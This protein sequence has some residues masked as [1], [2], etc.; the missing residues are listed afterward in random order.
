MLKKAFKLT[1][2]IVLTILVILFSLSGLQWAI[3]ILSSPVHYLVFS[4]AA[5]LAIVIII[6]VLMYFNHLINII[7]K[8]T[9]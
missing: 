3:G 5:V 2:Y 8:E 6:A 1:M 7:Q 9:K 4:G